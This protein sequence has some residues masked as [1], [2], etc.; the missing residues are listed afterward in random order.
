MSIAQSIYAYIS[1]HSDT[2]YVTGPEK[3]G[4][5]YTKYTCSYYGTYLMF[6]MCYSQSVSFIEFPIDFCMHDK[7]C[8]TIHNATKNL[9]TQNKVKFYV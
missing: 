5:I 9:N 2:L 3:T 6:W 4:L 1:L 7:N 8:T